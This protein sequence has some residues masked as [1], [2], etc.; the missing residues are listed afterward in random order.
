METKKS[1]ILAALLAFIGGFVGLQRFYLRE[2][3]AGI[4]FILLGVFTAF[5]VPACIGF[6]DAIRFL[7]MSP[8][9]FDRRYNRAFLHQ[10]RA[11]R[12]PMART[13][14]VR[15]ERN[16]QSNINTK[17]RANPYKKTGE[18]KY[19]EFDLKDA[20]ADFHKALEIE[21]NDVS[22]HFNLARAYSLEEKPEKSIFHLNQALR[23][24]FKDVEKIETHDDLAFLRIQPSFE[25]LKANGYQPQSRLKAPPK[26]NLLNDDVL[27]SQLNKLAELRKKGLLSESEFAVEKQ[28]LMTK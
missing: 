1:R 13:A 25:N 10:E 8:R 11:Q 24:G 9:D 18:Q 4:F 5:I 12:R 22:T 27:L 2:T 6:V 14:D 26:E 16:R 23:N 7:T 19:S 17:K 21:P 3:G 28:K 20:I 15:R